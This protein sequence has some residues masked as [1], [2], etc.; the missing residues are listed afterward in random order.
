MRPIVVCTV[1]REPK[2]KPFLR[3]EDPIYSYTSDYTGHGCGNYRCNMGHITALSAYMQGDTALVME[4]D[5]VMEDGKPWKEAVK[6]AECLVTQ[7]G[8]DLVSLHCRG[9]DMACLGKTVHE[10]SGF[11]FK[12][13]PNKD[14][15]VLN[16]T[17]AYVINR[18]AAWKFIQKD[19]FIEYNAIDCIMWS[20]QFNYCVL[21]NTPFIHGCGG[22][23]SVL[24]KPKNTHYSL[25]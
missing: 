6:I 3:F 16:G 24:E 1:H 12:M 23:E 8:F 2:V 22:E 25:V 15:Y 11:V 5:C 9:L 17:L 10:Q 20:P 7:G 19:P 4:D 21:D 13:P 18:K 14:H